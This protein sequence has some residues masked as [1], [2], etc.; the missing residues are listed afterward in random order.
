MQGV[1]SRPTNG[2]HTPP[3]APATVVKEVPVPDRE[4]IQ[5]AAEARA[6][7]RIAEA[8]VLRLEA[9]NA[10]LRGSI[11]LLEAELDE[12]LKAEEQAA[13]MAAPRPWWEDGDQVERKMD[14]LEGL[15]GR[16]FKKPGAPVLPAAGVTDEERELLAMAR[17]WKASAPEQFQEL[18]TQ[19]R[20]NFGTNGTT[21]Q[22]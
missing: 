19:L 17:Q 8:E 9:E 1:T 22:Q 21:E 18:T 11:Q 16:L 3:A 6:D 5:S 14:R 12:Q 4:A 2:P 10:Q 13:Q 7:A 15:V 20:A